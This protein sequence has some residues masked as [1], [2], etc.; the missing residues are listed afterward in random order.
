[1]DIFYWAFKEIPSTKFVLDLILQMHI[2]LILQKAKRSRCSLKV[3]DRVVYKAQNLQKMQ[4]AT[5]QPTE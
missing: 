3:F 5:A 2:V 1:M 4:I